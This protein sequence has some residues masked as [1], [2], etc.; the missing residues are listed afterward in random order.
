MSIRDFDKELQAGFPEKIYCLQSTQEFL[1]T[2]CIKDIKHT[3]TLTNCIVEEYNLASSDEQISAKD[4]I[5]LLNMMPFM[6][7]KRL[8]IINHG[9]RLSKKDITLI[10]KYSLDPSPFSTLLIFVFLT[11]K[12]KTHPFDIKPLTTIDLTPSQKEVYA[13]INK[14]TQQRGFT[15]TKKALD[16]LHESTG[17][18]VGLLYSE[19]MKF[20]ALGKEIVDIEDISE[21]TYAGVS[22][23]AFN[24][25]S[26]LSTGKVR[27]TFLTYKRMGENVEDFLLLGAICTNYLNFRSRHDKPEKVKRTLKILHEAD[28]LLKR[29][30]PAVIEMTL[31]RLLKVI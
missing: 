24:L 11:D 30:A 15:L 3:F 25:T 21:L 10:S 2:E 20:D 19:A 29:S 31:L 4:L 12:K 28:S 7:S 13:W 5:D 1:L 16:F 9:E 18:N 14:K 23:G 17:D 27:D 6:A 22:Y 26:V 8:V